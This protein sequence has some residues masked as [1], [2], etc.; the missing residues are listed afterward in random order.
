ML[1]QAGYLDAYQ[2]ML[3]QSG[4]ALQDW[5]ERG[6]LGRECRRLMQM[7][8]SAAPELRVEFEDALRD[9]PLRKAR[10]MLAADGELQD[11]ER[12]ELAVAA[13]NIA[14]RL[15]GRLARSLLDTRRRLRLASQQLGVDMPDLLLD[16]RLGI[17]ALPVSSSRLRT[18]VGERLVMI[19][20]YERQLLARFPSMVMAVAVRL[21]DLG[22]PRSPAAAS[23]TVRSGSRPPMAS[24]S[25]AAR[26]VAIVDR[27]TQ[28]F[29]A[30]GATWSQAELL[31]VLTAILAVTP[32]WERAL[33]ADV[34]GRRVAMAGELMQAYLNDP[35]VGHDVRE[36]LTSAGDAILK[37]ALCDAALLED[38]DHPLRQVLDRMA[39]VERRVGDRHARIEL[40]R[41][42]ADD[43]EAM[44]TDALARPVAMSTSSVAMAD[45][46][47]QLRDA[48]RL[49]QRWIGEAARE[50]ASAEIQARL[51][52][53]A[54]SQADQVFLGD[55]L[56]P[57]LAGL[58]L[59]LGDGHAS[60]T[61]M[62]GLL[63]RV[64][65]VLITAVE[66]DP[67]SVAALGRSLEAVMRTAGFSRLRR[68]RLLEAWQALCAAR[69]RRPAAAAQLPASELA[70]I[71]AF[72][73]IGVW[74]SV[75]D[76]ASMRPRYGQ[77][78]AIDT[79][80]GSVGFASITGR[81][82]FSRPAAQLLTGIRCGRV[83]P[84]SPD[85]LFYSARDRL[86]TAQ[87]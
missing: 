35:A 68:Q 56:E 63:D 32:D 13:H 53:Q 21:D 84:L 2:L 3:E 43:V 70:C 5:A 36:A 81:H 1:L 29:P 67:A 49:R 12:I 25:S 74:F 44:A 7:L 40:L 14:T 52:G 51:S 26:A 23:S 55:A 9:A 8:R 10:R 78:A 79:Q 73:R 48:V 38:A 4:E 17:D 28:V 18:D 27:L 57:M 61:L 60:W 71:L 76:A 45:F 39:V 83:F 85:P 31:R 24:D 69:P 59:R 42:L 58:L 30:V 34:V 15:E 20:L 86:I 77:V 65:A 6:E 47:Q 72:F 50:R 64:L 11:G 41:V 87:G 82:R 75:Q 22:I 33:P 19:R 66:P 54:V 80:T 37:V 46:R 16:P 62:L